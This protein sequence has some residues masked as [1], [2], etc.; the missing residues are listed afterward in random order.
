VSRDDLK[1]AADL[2]GNLLWLA[3]AIALIVLLA[4]GDLT[5]TAHFR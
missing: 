4:T 2:I 5:V 3:I 1:L